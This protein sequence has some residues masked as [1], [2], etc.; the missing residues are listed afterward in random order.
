ME[1][2]SVV[3]LLPRDSRLIYVVDDETMIGEVVEVILKLE[4]L[5]PK[6]FSNPE[7]AFQAFVTESPKPALLLTDFLMTP[8]NGMELIQR[9]K[10]VLPELKTILYSGN[11]REDIMQFY[12]VRPDAFLSKP[13]L[14]KTLV[15]VV[16]SVLSE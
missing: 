6:F 1:K 2:K 5:E 4:G 10:K 8:I 15:G 7:D 12:P 3:K 13:F 16:Q 11:V 14:P 9:C